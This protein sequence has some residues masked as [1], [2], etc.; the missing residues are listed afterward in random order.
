MKVVCACLLAGLLLGTT[1]VSAEG[2]IRQEQIKLEKG[3]ST[4]T[5][6]GKIKGHQ[7]VDYQLRASAGQSLVAVITASNRSAYFNVL[8][9][10]SDEALFVGSTLGNRFEGV[11]PADG[12]YTIR[13]YLMRNAAR[14]KETANYTLTVGLTG[15]GAAAATWR[16]VA[17]PGKPFDRTLELQGVRFHV[18]SANE[19]SVNTLQIVPA[20]LEIDNSPIVRT[21]DGTVTG[22][23]VA[24]LNVDGSPE[25][26][27]YVTSA[28]SGAY[29]SLVAY[30]V[31][32]RKSLSEISL[33]PVTQDKA[34]SQGYMGHD[35]FAVVESVLV[36]RFPVYRAADTNAKP[37]GG[38]RQLQYK[39]VPGEAGWIL[40]VDRVVEY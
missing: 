20:S 25:I 1:L 19:G 33:P 26:Y 28:G 23:E 37:T 34:T 39:L 6:T 11:L 2:A 22:A 7:T 18:T 30:S 29:G 16:A 40:K 10:G 17:E 8:P 14:R 13:V 36:R 24:D 4:A 32:R 38:A 35:E 12:L 27:V 3:T 21:I 31:N 9:P 15:G 5:I